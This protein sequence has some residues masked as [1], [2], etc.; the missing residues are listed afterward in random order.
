MKKFTGYMDSN[1][2]RI[3]GNWKY[4]NDDRNLY[5]FDFVIAAGVKGTLH[6]EFTNQIGQSDATEEIVVNFK[7]KEI[8]Q[9]PG[10]PPHIESFYAI[11]A[12][13]Q[14]ELCFFILQRDV[15]FVR[16]ETSAYV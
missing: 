1:R 3:R 14:A 16:T 12:V 2:S 5:F 8:K 9:A 10:Y 15:T 7:D 13:D 4:D 6:M 11:E